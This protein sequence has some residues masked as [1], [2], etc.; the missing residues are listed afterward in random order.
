MLGFDANSIYSDFWCQCPPGFEGNRCE[1]LTQN[2]PCTLNCRN[3]GVCGLENFDGG[4]VFD[5]YCVCPPGYGGNRCHWDFGDCVPECQNG[6]VCVMEQLC[7]D[8]DVVDCDDDGFSIQK[9]CDCPPEYV[10][11]RCEL[12]CDLNC[13]N[14]G[15]CS[16]ASLVEEEQGANA[17]A[18]YCDCPQG[19][20]GADCEFRGIECGELT[21]SN[22]SECVEASQTT[23][24]RAAGDIEH[25]CDCTA[26]STETT[27]FAGRSC[28][29]KSTAICSSGADSPNGPRFCVNG[30]GCLDESKGGCE[31]LPGF[32]GSRCEFSLEE[33]EDGFAKCELEC[34]NEGTC[35]EGF[36]PLGEIFEPFAGS[37]DSLFNQSH[38]D[39][40]H[41]NCPVG[42][43]GA[44]CEFEYKL[45]GA[46]D[47]ICFYGSS[48]VEVDGEFECDCN[49][50]ST[51]AA[52]LFC[53]HLATEVCDETSGV[54]CTNGGTCSDDINGYVRKEKPDRGI[55]VHSYCVKSQSTFSAFFTLC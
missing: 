41:C 24:A 29:Y 39:F 4:F 34:L 10:G 32:F 47:Y 51:F 31:C 7:L 2:I 5:E 28:Q 55:V 13:L 8:E 30:G 45:C 19:F 6:G 50:A 22:G 17:V 40:E 15:K 33:F 26:A 44:R 46:G 27:Y 54:F 38:V 21:C 43:F 3:G 11:S 52:G 12:P 48:C 20:F 9:F 18:A 16:L 49:E 42:F 1:F 37:V 35:V 36:K 23:V 25:Y 53:Q 14:G